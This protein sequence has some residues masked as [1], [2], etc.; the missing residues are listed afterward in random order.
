MKIHES[1]KEL[2]NILEKVSGKYTLSTVFQDMVTMMAI[3]LSNTVDMEQ[4]DT[5]E[6]EYLKIA[7]R[8]DKETHDIFAQF[9]A[10]LVLALAEQPSDYLGSVYMQMNFNNSKMGQHF[11]PHH[12][13]GLLAELTLGDVKSQLNER[14]RIST[15]DMCCGGGQLIIGMYNVLTKRGYDPTQIMEAYAKDLGAIPAMMCYIQLFLLN[16]PGVVL[17]GNGLSDEVIQE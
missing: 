8:Y 6:A 5:R 9:F 11:T 10:R 17:Q 12:V 16:C 1:V 13:A 4:Y 14:G 7:A 3:A 15:A 2:T